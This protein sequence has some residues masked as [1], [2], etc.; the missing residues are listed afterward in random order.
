MGGIANHDVTAFFSKLVGQPLHLVHTVGFMV[1]RHDKVSAAPIAD[2]T[3]DKSMTVKKSMNR[4]VDAARQSMTTRFDFSNALK[5][6]SEPAPV[7]K[8]KEARIGMKPLQR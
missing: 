6:P 3:V 7:G 5:M 4:S 1:D 8:V 2:N